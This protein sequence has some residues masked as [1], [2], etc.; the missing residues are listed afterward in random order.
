MYW[1]KDFQTVRSENITYFG[2]ASRKFMRGE[3]TPRDR[4]SG[5]DEGKLEYKEYLRREIERPYRT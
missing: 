5:R 3:K 4:S 1:R 2:L